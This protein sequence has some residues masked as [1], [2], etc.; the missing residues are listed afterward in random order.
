MIYEAESEEMEEKSDNIEKCRYVV[1]DP[2]V[3]RVRT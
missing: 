3:L 1:N 2:M